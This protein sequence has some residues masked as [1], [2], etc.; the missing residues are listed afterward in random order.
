MGRKR[1]NAIGRFDAGLVAAVAAASA[2]GAALAGCSPTGTTAFDVAWSALLGTSV[3]WA[4]ASAPWRVL[5]LASGVAVLFT[6]GSLSALCF[7]VVALGGSAWLAMRR[8]SVPLVRA[9]IGAALVQAALR[10]SA[11]PFTFATALVAA[12]VLGTVFV[13][14]LQRRNRLIR[15]RVSLTLAALA[16]FFLVG[17]AGLGAAAVSAK[18]AASSGYSKL[19]LGLDE[20]G[21]GNP[22]A[23]S[24]ALRQAVTNLSDAGDRLGAWWAQPSAATPVLA[25]NRSAV[26]GLLADAAAAAA[27]AADAL[28]VVDLDRLRVVNGTIDVAAVALLETPL[29]TLDKT[30]HRLREELDQVDSPWLLGPVA[31][32]IASAR[33]RSDAV[34]VQAH[35]T[36]L[37]ARVAPAMLGADKPRRY[38]MAFASPAESRGTVGVIGNWAEIVIDDGSIKLS[39]RGRATDLITGT[40]AAGAF[41]FTDLPPEVYRRFGSVGAGG[42]TADVDPKYWSNVTMSPDMPTV[43]GQMAALY[44]HATTRRVDGVFLLDPAAVAGL[45]QVIGPVDLPEAGITLRAD[46][47]EQFLLRGQYVKSTDDRVDLLAEATDATVDQ[48]LASALPGPQVIARTLGP[49]ALGGHLSAWARQSEE[50]QMLETVGIDGGLPK[51]RGGDGLGV[52]LDNAA[53]NKIDSFIRTSVDYSASVNSTGVVT[54]TAVVTLVNTAPTKIGRAHV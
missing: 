53:G 11:N 39:H 27:D 52:T 14:G 48:L 33:D 5:L 18:Q 46:T 8:A 19:L 9:G 7:A 28:D 24:A 23:A 54:S 10:L 12:A 42:P 3:T 51:L 47:A 31:D 15:R 32:R 36:A 49:I 4:A 1:R 40:A 22:S 34:A 16:G 30:V 45:L 43:A 21:R 38:L 41:R 26:V 50:Q 35:G 13:A 44:E 25:P 20:V 17:T 6:G 29:A 37:A 2:V